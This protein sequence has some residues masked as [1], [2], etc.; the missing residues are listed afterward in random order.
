MECGNIQLTMTDVPM[1]CAG[2]GGPRAFTLEAA[3]GGFR[4]NLD[5]VMGCKK[6]GPNQVREPQP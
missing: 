2:T 1:M 3:A 5:I 4:V 6:S